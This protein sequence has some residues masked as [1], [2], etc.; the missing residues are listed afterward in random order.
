LTARPAQGIL[1]ALASDLPLLPL[2]L[3]EP[4]LAAFQRVQT[5]IWVYDMRGHCHCWANDAALVIWRS[6]SLQ[7]FVSRDLGPTTAEQLKTAAALLATLK[8]GS[9]AS[10]VRTFMPQGQP[11]TLR[12]R[13]TPAL[14]R[15]RLVGLVEAHPTELIE[16]ESAPGPGHDLLQ[17][18]MDA[19]PVP[20]LST[21][22]GQILRANRAAEALLDRDPDRGAT[23]LTLLRELPLQDGEHVGESVLPELDFVGVVHCRRVQV[24][25]RAARL[26]ALIDLGEQRRL[27]SELEQARANAEAG[28]RSKSAFLATVSHEL[29]TPMNGVLGMLQLLQNSALAEADA[30][31]VDVAMRSGVM[32]LR[33]LDDLVEF[34]RAESTRTVSMTDF[35]PRELTDD[36][37]NL[38]RADPRAKGLELSV[39]VHDHVPAVLHAD[40]SAARQVLLNLVGNAVKFTR[41]GHVVVDVDHQ[42]DQLVIRVQDSGIGID[43]EDLPQLFHSFTQADSSISRRFG[44]TGLGLAI[45]KRLLERQGGSIWAESEPGVGSTFGFRLPAIGVHL[46]PQE[47]WSSRE[48]HTTP[49]RRVLLVEDNPVDQLVASR[50]LA[51]LG[52]TVCVASSGREALELVASF[53]PDVV[54]M[55]LHMPGLSGLD[56]VAALRLEPDV[57]PIPIIPM[58]AD[59]RSETR[60]ACAEAGMVGFQ[61]KPLRASDLGA[62]LRAL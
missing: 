62:A 40:A 7:E 12:V 31:L 38:L 52:Q 21:A 5:P 25:D 57:G 18:G 13:I 49:Q 41:E 36:V 30:Q 61:L 32:L 23:L 53:K 51:A 3:S 26:T 50:F 34:A 1:G 16:P 44:G 2:A 14:W 35:G 10:M 45:C 60:A 8:R 15:G 48:Q 11:V 24:G 43:A 55:D 42:D 47:G 33:L 59:G 58:T 28:S 37:V 39:R 22:E 19:A 46:P 27:Q 4:V 17:A 29:R 9:A 6:D 54:L 56:T 20:L